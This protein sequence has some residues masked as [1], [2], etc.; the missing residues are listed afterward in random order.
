[1]A[2]RFQILMMAPSKGRDYVTIAISIFV[3][4]RKC[5]FF[6]NPVT[7]IKSPSFCVQISPLDVMSVMNS[8]TNLLLRRLDESA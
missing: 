8:F 5:R 3:K 6:A 4:C 2:D 7:N 1:M